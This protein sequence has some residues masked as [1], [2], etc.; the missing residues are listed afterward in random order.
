MATSPGH[1]RCYFIFTLYRNKKC[2]TTVYFIFV[3][4]ASLSPVGLAVA[5]TASLTALRLVHLH[6]FNR[7][8]EVCLCVCVCACMRMCVV[9]KTYSM[10]RYLRF[11]VYIL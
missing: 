8:T 5:D 7:W 4:P 10:I 2:V 11:Y 1:S 9:Y 3:V 6:F